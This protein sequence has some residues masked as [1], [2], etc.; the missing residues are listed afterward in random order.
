MIIIDG[1]EVG[2]VYGEIAVDD[3]EDGQTLASSGVWYKLTQFDTNGVALQ[4]TPD[5]VNDRITVL[6]PGVYSVTFALSFNGSA[7]VTYHIAI[8]IGGAINT[9]L[10]IQRRIGA[11]NDVGAV[12]IAGLVAIGAGQTVEAYISA[13]GD[14]KDFIMGHGSLAVHSVDK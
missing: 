2:P 7:N 5:H 3:A 11:G 9:V 10:K 13:D 1:V 6:V 8:Y 4:T 12:T 14:S